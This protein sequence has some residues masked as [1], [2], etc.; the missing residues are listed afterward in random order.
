MCWA[1]FPARPGSFGLPVPRA[2]GVGVGPS[3]PTAH[4]AGPPIELLFREVKVQVQALT[5]L[6]KIPQSE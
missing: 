1:Q 3:S 4:I 6:Y 2:R 5:N